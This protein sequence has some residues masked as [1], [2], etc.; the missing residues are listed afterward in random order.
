M[1]YLIAFLVGG[2]LGDIFGVLTMCAM[3]SAGQADDRE[4]AWFDD[5]SEKNHR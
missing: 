5:Q 4:E 2:I 3:V 1:S